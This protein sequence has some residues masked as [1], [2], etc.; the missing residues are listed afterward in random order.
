MPYR[1]GARSDIRQGYS[2]QPCQTALLPTGPALLEENHHGLCNVHLLRKLEE[3][4]VELEKEPDRWAAHMQ[5][6]LLEARDVV[7]YWGETTGGPVPVLDHYNLP[8]L[9]RGRLPPGLGLSAS[10]SCGAW[11]RPPDSRERLLDVLRLDPDA[12]LSQSQPNLA[13]P[14]PRL[15][16]EENRG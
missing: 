9:D 12:A 6:Q 3:V 11:L 13:S 5:R 15:P 1:L 2:A 8:P 7:T 16:S 10:P 4:S 14:K